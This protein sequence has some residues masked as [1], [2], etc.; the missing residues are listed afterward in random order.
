[1]G[2]LERELEGDRG[3]AVVGELGKRGWG[4]YCT[5]FVGV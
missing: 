3:V 2:E 1:V 4:R 5:E